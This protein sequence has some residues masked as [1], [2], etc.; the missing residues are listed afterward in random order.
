[1]SDDTIEWGG[2][3]DFAWA[4][5]D[6]HTAIVGRNGTGKSQF[7]FFVLSLRDFSKRATIVIDYKREKLFRM[8]KNI[9]EIGLNEPLPKKGGL[10]IVRA[11][12]E[13]DDDE[14]EQMLWKIWQRE[15]LGLFV[16]EG[17]SLPN[18]GKSRAFKAILTQGRAK[19]IPAITLSQRP[20]GLSRAVFTESHHVVAFHLN[21]EDDKKTV[22]RFTGR[23]FLSELPEAMKGQKRLPPYHAR[24]YAQK[25]HMRFVLAPVPAAEEIA[26]SIDAQLEPKR[27]WF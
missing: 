21:D 18:D 11:L 20:V 25:K 14:M 1:M 16:D 8:L 3:K 26:A 24:W 6:E 19:Y 17:Y 5:P 2:E 9:R 12:P 27:R 22:E 7:G 13:V 23:G 4:T 10:Y 15:K